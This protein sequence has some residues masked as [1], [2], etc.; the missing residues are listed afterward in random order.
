MKLTLHNLLFLVLIIW[1]SSC[2]R[3]DQHQVANF[4]F[5]KDELKINPYSGDELLIFKD[6]NGDTISFPRGVR[7][8]KYMRFYQYDYE[9][10]K[11]DHHGCQGVYFDA[12][13]NYMSKYNEGLARSFDINLYFRYSLNNPTSDKA[14]ELFIFITAQ[15]HLSF[16][17]YYYFKVDTL[18]NI[19]TNDQYNKDSIV[20]YHPQWTSGTKIFYNVYEL[21]CHKGDPRDT[22]WISTA[23]YSITEG[24]VGFRTTF[25]KSWYLDKIN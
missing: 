1:I 18:L 20:G 4:Q 6:F 7:Y 23:Y 24:L 16:H 15:P 10:A 17:G 14:F 8:T 3:C 25:G 19:K 5:T 11:L 12:D 13:I 9:T 21:Y 2:N 22:A